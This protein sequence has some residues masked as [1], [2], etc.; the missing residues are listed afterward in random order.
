MSNAKSL[1][2][3]LWY[4]LSCERVIG[5]SGLVSQAKKQMW[6][7]SQGLSCGHRTGAGPAAQEEQQAR[8][9][10]LLAASGRV[11]C[12]DEVPGVLKLEVESRDQGTMSH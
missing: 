12:E 4:R 8:R 10:F 9:L 6:W 5:R 7:R 2:K 1:E 3:H 11:A